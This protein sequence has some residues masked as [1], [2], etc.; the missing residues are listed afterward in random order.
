MTDNIIIVKK[1]NEHP[2]ALLKKFSLLFRSSGIM[3]RV[4]SLKT[5]EKKNS[6]FKTKKE[7]LRK[8]ER[9]IIKE[10]AEKL[11]KIK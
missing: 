10:R 9:L 6:K 11:G 1:K 3:P 7:K 5:N 2:G 4:K 8:I